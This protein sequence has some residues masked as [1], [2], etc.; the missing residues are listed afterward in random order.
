MKRFLV[1]IL[2][3]V[4]M[5]SAVYAQTN[6]VGSVNAVGYMKV[7]VPSNGYALVSLQL[8]GIGGATVTMGSLVGTQLPV[9][10]KAHIWKVA[11]KQYVVENRTRTGW[12][13]NTLDLGTG[14]W[15]E[16]PAA[17]ATGPTHTVTF[18]GE[19]PSAISG[20]SSVTISG[21]TGIDAMGYTYPASVNWTNTSLARDAIAGD[22]LHVWN[23]AITNYNVYNK[24][25]GGWSTPADYMLNPGQGF[26]YETT[27][28][29]NWNVSI[30]YSL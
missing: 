8:N 26:W 29:T 14:F 9:G 12:G 6:E 10:S 23:P 4:I 3:T 19:V 5:S 30:P 21:I 24:T 16:V 2:V 7:V 20:D 15:L 18:Q 13:T 27:G 25:R 11:Q 28:S 17:S 1:V 22:K